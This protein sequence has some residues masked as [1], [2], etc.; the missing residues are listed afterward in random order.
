M[1]ANGV[2]PCSFNSGSTDHM[3]LE[4]V[5]HAPSR[6]TQK[7]TAKYY[8]ESMVSDERP[9]NVHLLHNWD[10]H[11]INHWDG[12][13]IR[14]PVKDTESP[15]ITEDYES[16]STVARCRHPIIHWKVFLSFIIWV[17]SY[18]LMAFFGGS[19]AFMH[20]DR[21]ELSPNISNKIIQ[22]DDDAA[23]L[24]LTQPLPDLGYDIIE[25]YCPKAF[26]TNPQSIVLL[27]LYIVIIAGCIFHPN[28][29]R[30]RLMFQQL[31]HTNTFIFL[32]R[33]TTVGITGLPQ[34]NPVCVPT[35]YDP[36]S[37]WGA[38]KYVVFRG[39]PPRACGD[40]IYSGHA[41][42]ILVATLLLHRYTYFI[43]AKN[44]KKVAV[45]GLII[46]IKAL[47][48]VYFTIACRSH[49]SVDVILGVY[50]S[51][52][53]SEFYYRRSEGMVV[54]PGLLTMFIQ[55]LEDYEGV[56]Q[57]KRLESSNP[58]IVRNE[59]LITRNESLSTAVYDDTYNTDCDEDSRDRDDGTKC[60]YRLIS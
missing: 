42:C 31:L 25:Y 23:L 29:R 10:G 52:L 49:Y 44:W 15:G 55:W 28:R 27:S 53:W 41:A 5:S 35:Q 56:N 59:S 7:N 24:A 57:R 51:V 13:E 47:T 40:L 6:T 54:K 16:D 32:S 37:Y 46:W 17:I 22:S 9:L 18:Y 39:F 19:V 60:N 12:Y 38:V 34:P 26:N 33:T 3:P 8:D 45:A 20:F 50:M 36:V 1:S 43:S 30:G 58:N 48:G 2:H 4:M 11:L 21:V 14:D